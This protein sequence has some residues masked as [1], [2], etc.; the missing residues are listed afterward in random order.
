MQDKGS[1]VGERVDGIDHYIIL[2]EMKVGGGLRRVAATERPYIGIRVDL[3]HASAHSLDL[4]LTYG[5]R[6]GGELTV[7]VGLR[8]A[9]GVDH[10]HM[11]DTCAD[12][13]LDSPAADASHP[14]YNNARTAE[15]FGGIIA[16]QPAHA[17]QRCRHR[18]MRG[19]DGVKFSR[20]WQNGNADGR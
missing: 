10:G 18:S 17:V 9:I 1:L 4:H 12:K 19:V 11:S 13:A 20:H 14:E 16:Q 5:E 8:D 2:F 3:Q 7:D 6:G 15:G